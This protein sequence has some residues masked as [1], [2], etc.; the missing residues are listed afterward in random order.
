[1][2]KANSILASIL[3]I[4][5]VVNVTWAH[6]QKM[7]ITRVELN[8]RTNMLEVMHRFDL[9]DAEHAVGKIFGKGADIIGSEQTQTQFANYVAERFAMF[10]PNNKSMPLKLV[11]FEKEGKHFWVYQETPKPESLAGVQIVHNALRDIWFA[12][13]NTVNVKINDMIETL[14]FTENTEVL[15]IEFAR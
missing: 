3:L 1:M 12:Q 6:Q 8:P 10:T 5:A 11:G 2:N 14:T 13:T 7:A 15:N 9:H 4:V